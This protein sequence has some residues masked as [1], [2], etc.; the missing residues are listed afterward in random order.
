VLVLPLLTTSVNVGVGEKGAPFCK[1]LTQ[2]EDS[3]KPS[4]LE[5]KD[6][7]KPWGYVRNKKFI[8]WDRKFDISTPF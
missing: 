7:R 4:S 8:A 6:G 3:S 2:D 1:V 5:R